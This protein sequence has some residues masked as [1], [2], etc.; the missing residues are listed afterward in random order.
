MI[1]W[2][3]GI[4]RARPAGHSLICYSKEAQ[5]SPREADAEL[6]QRAAP[7]DRL[8]HSFGQFIEFVVH[9]FPSVLDVENSSFSL[10]INRRSFFW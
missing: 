8:G 4:A 3:V 10:R 1:P 7:R 5:C 2:A 9:N 6:L